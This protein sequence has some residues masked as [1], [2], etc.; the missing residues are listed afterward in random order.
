MKLG[1]AG[2]LPHWRQIDRPAAERV[3]AAGFRGASVVIDRPLEAERASVARVRSAFVEAGLEA[4]QANG[5]YE[6]LVSPDEARRAAGVAGLQALCRWGRLLDAATVYVRPGGL[7][8]GGPW[9]PHPDNHAPATFDR[10]VASLR[11]VCP[12]AEAEGVRLA[13]EGH[14]LSPLDSAARVAEL[15]TAVASPS[16]RFN[17]DPVNF[18]GTVRDAHDTRRV[19]NELFD[20]LGSHTAA[21]HVKDC[22]LGNA[23]VVHIEEVTPGEGTLDLPLYLRRFAASCPGGYLLIEHLPDAAVPA[24][25][26]AVCRAAERA[27]LAFE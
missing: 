26:V 20:V 21:G 19:I 3:R 16:L 4:A 1:V 23:L 12:V 18:I 6:P 5:W 2:L 7:N 24:A 15:L 17:V 13:I 9:R 10:L 27:G 11:Q 14:V 22:A 8:P 25:R